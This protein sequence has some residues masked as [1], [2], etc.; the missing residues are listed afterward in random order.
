MNTGKKELQS[1]LEESALPEPLTVP[2][3]AIGKATPWQVSR[4]R[5]AS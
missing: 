5:R 3:A 1:I 2:V 4:E